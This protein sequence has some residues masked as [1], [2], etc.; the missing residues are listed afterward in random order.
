MFRGK[1]L[2]KSVLLLLLLLLFA[3]ACSIAS[4]ISDVMG[5]EPTL[6][7]PTVTQRRSTAAAISAATTTTTDSVTRASVPSS[8]TSTPDPSTVTP[9]PSPVPP[10]LSIRAAD[11]YLYP[12]PTIF[13]GQKVTFQ[14]LPFVPENVEPVEVSVRIL[15]DDAEIVADSLVGRS[16]LSGEAVGLFQWAWDTTGRIGSHQVQIELD[17]QDTIQEGDENPDNNEVTLAVTVHDPQTQPASSANAIWKTAESGCCQVHV[18]SGT[19][20]DRDLPQLLDAVDA[21]V[22]QATNRLGEPAQQRLDVYLIDRIIG[23]GGYAGSGM[24]VSYLDRDYANNNL[25]QVLVHEAVHLLDRQFAPQR[26]GFFTEG[27]A[28]WASDGH[29]QPEDINLAAAALLE[30]GHYVP[31][32]QLIN[33][34]YP[35]QHEIGYLEAAG[36]VTY[37]VDNFGWPRFRTFYSDTIP[38]E[39]QTLA[40]MV[41]LKLREHYGMSLEILETEWLSYLE[42]LPWDRLELMKV[43]TMIR[44]YNTMR[45][46]QLEYD[47]TAHFM[48]AWLPSPRS[49]QE[50]G[51]PSDLSGHPETLINVTLEVMLQAAGE[52]MSARDYNRANVLLGSVERVLTNQRQ[53]IDPF[54]V[55]Y[56]E[57]VNI[58]SDQGYEVHRVN[59]RGDKATVVVS[60]VDS[61]VL[62]ELQMEMDE[63]A[64]TRSN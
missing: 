26:I 39:G 55:N 9:I 47:P 29:Y 38:S 18:A 54:A 33:R 57:I 64:W 52:A 16:H 41:D 44:Y 24:V 63:Q 60:P 45:R 14:L 36:I 48:R 11:I 40:E 23:Q 51:S 5:S 12:V 53:F 20:A 1:Q 15:V 13:A 61:V 37:L 7:V 4:N 3:T 17:W 25:H 6:P 34:F 49:V 22:R 27:L 56:W 46:Y 28:V 50:N 19:A 62:D 58:L 32:Q 42:S 10:D 59:L 8:P 43:Q 2:K 21:A 30:S 35:V 31:L